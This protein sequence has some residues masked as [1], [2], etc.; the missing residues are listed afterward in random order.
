MDVESFEEKDAEISDQQNMFK[1]QQQPHIDI[2][3]ALLSTV[4]EC[5]CSNENT[6]Y[7]VNLAF[8]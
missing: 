3:D 2:C 8:G 6:C 1:K 4:I 7:T 5:P